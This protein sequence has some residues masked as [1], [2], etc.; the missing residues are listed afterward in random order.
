MSAL[1]SPSGVMT[2]ALL[3]LPAVAA[4]APRSAVLAQFTVEAGPLDR[5]DSPTS[6]PLPPSLADRALEI[7][8]AGAWYPLALDPD[9]EG[10]FLLPAL[11]K[12]QRRTLTL[13]EARSPARAHFGRSV[14]V[15]KDDDG[16]W[17]T[18][19]GKRLLRYQARPAAPAGM[20]EDFLRGGYLHPV[21]TPS[22]V[23][24]TDDYPADHKH[25][26][27]IWTAWTHTEYEGRTPDFWNMGQRKARKDHV[28]IGDTFSGADAG[29]FI[30]RLSSTDL[31]ATP[32]RVVIDERWKV[33]A[34]RMPARSGAR[35]AYHLF[36]LEWTDTVLG[37]SPL[38]LPEY[39]YGGLG[40]RGP[41]DWL[42]ETQTTFL[43]S[44]GKDRQ[45]AENS[46]ARW[47]HMG[48]LVR[49]KESGNPASKLAGIAALDH[50]A[51]FRHPQPL[52][53]SPNQPYFVYS[54]MKAGPFT[55][56]AGKPF[57]SRYRFVVSDGPADPA[58]LER[59]W[60][61]FARP[62]TVTAL[63]AP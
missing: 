3:L 54:P 57:V 26:H 28:S 51:N 8:G 34:Y 49:G 21:F 10:H 16:L 37:S 46:P 43:T 45:S 55:I 61:D 4:G 32:P 31:Q 14:V 24:V 41:I 39:R 15:S 30:A 59:L 7:G 20:R 23:L 22:G 47:C 6:V 42:G 11:K 17:L 36:D 13:R 48:G 56:E 53:I 50:P 33:I 35:R 5:R 2:V 44:E 19:G 1:R 52:R 9:G 29:G 58:L 25:H 12:G 18:V 63:P 38:K 40:V 27:G 62:P 60:Q